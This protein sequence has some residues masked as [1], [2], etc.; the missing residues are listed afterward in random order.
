MPLVRSY[1]VAEFQ[2][3]RLLDT[4]PSQDVESIEA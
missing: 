4:L 3:P 2:R 1:T